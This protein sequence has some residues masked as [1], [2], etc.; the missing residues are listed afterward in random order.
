MMGER[1]LPIADITIIRWVY[2]YAPEFVQ[3]WN[4]FAWPCGSSWRVDE[5]HLKIL[6]GQ[7]VYLHRTVDRACKTVDFRL[8]PRR[9]VAAAK[10]FFRK[11]LRRQGSAARTITLDGHAPSHRAVREMKF[12]GQ[13]A[14]DTKLRSS[15]DLNNLFEQD[16]RGVTLR[17]GS[18]FGL[19]EVQ[20]RGSHHPRYRIAATD[21]QGPIQSRRAAPQRH[22]CACPPE[23]SV[24][25]AME[26]VLLGSCQTQS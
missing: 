14:E 21:P 7:R 4:R 8:S 24:S 23:H 2:H 13:L 11:A 9:N 22:R 19:I 10:A 25:S 5:T 18:M 20:V 1:G 26:E 15:K 3:R 16:H 6:L 12:D 17:I